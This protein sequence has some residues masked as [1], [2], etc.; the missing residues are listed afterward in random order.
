MSPL[1]QKCGETLY[2]YI[3]I[4]IVCS[5]LVDLPLVFDMQENK[6]L[7]CERGPFKDTRKDGSNKERCPYLPVSKTS[8]IGQ[9]KKKQKPKKNN[10][11]LT[12]EVNNFVVFFPLVWLLA[13]ID[14]ALPS[15]NSTLWSFFFLV[16]MTGN[17]IYMLTLKTLNVIVIYDF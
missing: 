15:D 8:E 11:V 9:R 3:F 16:K 5:D 7:S 13:I 17:C 4:Y 2:I 10:K 12:L 1:R 6:R 14:L